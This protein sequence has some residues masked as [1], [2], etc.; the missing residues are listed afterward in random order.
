MPLAGVKIRPG[1]QVSHDRASI[2]ADP[3]DHS[4]GTPGS[5]LR[6]LCWTSRPTAVAQK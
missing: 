5:N 1:G 3:P 6:E 4:A 2:P